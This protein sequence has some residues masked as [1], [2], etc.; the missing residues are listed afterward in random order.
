MLLMFVAGT[1][2]LAW[3]LA[4]GAIMAVEK[5]APWGRGISAPLGAI[6][7]A[8]GVLVV[9]WPDGGSAHPGD[10]ADP[11]LGRQG[12]PAADAAAGG[13]DQSTLLVCPVDPCMHCGP[14]PAEVVVDEQ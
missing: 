14:R 3:M 6:L 8:A 2:S 10:E 12:P 1:A 4:L 5:N 9:S 7:L 11:G 13:Q